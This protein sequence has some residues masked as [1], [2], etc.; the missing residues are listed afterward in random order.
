MPHEAASARVLSLV[1]TDLVG[2]TDLKARRGDD[3]AGALIARHR[4]HV[5]KLAR[6]AGGR[7]V[8]FAGDGCFLAF[9]APSTAALF[10]LRLQQLH[11]AE[12]ELPHVRIGIHLGEVSERDGRVE[13]LAVDLAARIQSLARPGQVL[14]SAAAAASA[15]QRLG[16]E[17]AGRAV[18]WKSHG[19][20]V[21][22][23][24]S[25]PLE[26]VEV[27]LAGV[28]PFAPPL[29]GEKARPV[30]RALPRRALAGLGLALALCA[31]VAAY[32]LFAG[33]GRLAPIR[34]IAVLPLENLS[35]D[36]AQDYFADGMTEALIG[37]LAKLGALD[38][39]SRTS[40][41]QY[42]GAHRPL[43]E[44]A[45]ELGVDGIIEGS[46]LRDGEEVRITAQLIDARSDHHLWSESYQRELRTVLAIQS[47]VARAVARQIELSLTPGES[48]RLAPPAAVDPR[49]QDAYFRGR[50]L[51]SSFTPEGVRQSIGHFEE[52]IRIAPDYAL[53]HAAESSAW[54]LL[55]Q[56]LGA[57]PPREAL[58]KAKAAALRAL[59]LD[60]D[61]GEAHSALAQ[62]LF[63]F[64]WNFEAAERE[65][66]GA[67]ELSPSE[68]FADIGYAF[69]LLA[70]ERR[71]EAYSHMDEAIRL[72]PM[73]PVARAA[74]IDF[75]STAGRFDD[76]HATI[77]RLLELDPASPWPLEREMRLL[78]YEGRLE[79]ALA[80]GRKIA[81]FHPDQAA[82]MAALEE[83]W[84]KD[85]APGY[86]RF[87]QQEWTRRGA[88]LRAAEAYTAAGAIDD[89][90]GALER[91]YAQREGPLIFLAVVPSF[92]PLHADPRFAELVRRMRLPRPAR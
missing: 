78:E 10:A 63:F 34:S 59:A 64:E 91:A 80:T 65:F 29:A 5:T 6:E 48:A 76:A 41:M 61:L 67:S 42:K 62:A 69:L 1:F 33:G 89:A 11:S 77:D 68:S 4:E 74:Q 24:A 2:S 35:G 16:S 9:E 56:P 70:L 50:Q 38:V 23:G 14:V 81:E 71:A 83:A 30:S 55:G 47:E 84:R 53:P 85:G 90:F 22:K 13:G 75:F 19:P 66:R 27:G 37:E 73:D 25:E 26:V 82:E 7:I 39:I 58:P 57:V 46:V 51:W 36:P 31:A 8:D 54:F 15:R 52:A 88:F 49:A 45:N 60:E 44:I 40:V 43:R 86:W 72:S 79:A 18:Q 32:L 12:P 20:Y 3:A 17:V 28:G 87:W 92:A 21:L